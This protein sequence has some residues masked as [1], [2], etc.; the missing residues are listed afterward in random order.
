MISQRC[1][2]RLHSAASEPAAAPSRPMLTFALSLLV[3]RA[4]AQSSAQAATLTIESGGQVI[5]GANGRLQVGEAQSPDPPPLYVGTYDCVD[6][7]GVNGTAGQCVDNLMHIYADGRVSGDDLCGHSMFPIG[8]GNLTGKCT[9]VP[10]TL[11]WTLFLN[12]PQTSTVTYDGNRIVNN[13][14]GFVWNRV[15]ANTPPAAPPSA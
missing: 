5:I 10:C 6:P 13:D 15:A 14:N 3:A 11:T 12:P 1:V 9:E 4:G 2:G 7:D 8:C